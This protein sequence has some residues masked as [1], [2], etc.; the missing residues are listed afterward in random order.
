MSQHA[1]RLPCVQVL[2]LIE[3]WVDGELEAGRAASVQAHVDSCSSC[4]AE[5]RLADEIRAELRAMPN[6]EL[7]ERLLNDIA[8]ATEPTLPSRFR[9]V[10]GLLVL[11]PVPAAVAVAAIVAVLVIQPWRAPTDAGYTETEVA[12]A[13]AETKLALA[14]V[15]G[16]SRRAQSEIRERVIEG[17]PV[18]MTVRRISRSMNWTGRPGSN[19]PKPDGLPQEHSEGSSL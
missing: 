8:Q 15:G 5:M 4:N 14:Y 2:E 11:R 19:E 10:L 18:A 1:D 9:R 6:Y 16:V 7:P 3:P 12:R 13:T 17:E